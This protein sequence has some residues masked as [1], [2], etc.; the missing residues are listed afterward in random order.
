MS[1]NRYEVLSVG[2]KTITVE[3]WTSLGQ[4]KMRLK[5]DE[6]SQVKGTRLYD[7][8]TQDVG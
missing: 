5:F 3:S 4:S 7:T 8:I 1:G 6:L 2:K